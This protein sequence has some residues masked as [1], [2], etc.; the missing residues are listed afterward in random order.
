MKQSELDIIAKLNEQTNDVIQI[1][2]HQYNRFDAYNSQAIFEIKNRGKFYASTMIEFDKYSYNEM[3][4]QINKLIFLYVVQMEQMIYIFN[5]SAL[6]AHFYDFNWGWR[7]LPA[8]T[9]FENNSDKE[10]YV[11]YT[12]IVDELPKYIIGSFAPSLFQ[13][14]IEKKYEIRSFYLKG[15]FYSMAIFSQND[16]QTEIDFRR[17]NDFVP[18]RTIPYNSRGVKSNVRC[19][20]TDL[21]LNSML[22]HNLR[23]VHNRCGTSCHCNQ[24]S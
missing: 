21:Q 5:V 13:S 24:Q 9:E 2:S 6:T 18:N 7:K 8:S 4:S 12:S 1:S 10:K 11:G 16:T 17:Y 14:K 19:S 22:H 20:C 3:Y 23:A 15:K